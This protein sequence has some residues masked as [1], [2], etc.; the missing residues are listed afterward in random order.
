MAIL[1]SAALAASI[2]LGLASLAQAAELR[3]RA[4]SAGDQVP[5]Q[6]TASKSTAART[7]DRTPVQVSWALEAAEP[8][9]DRP[10]P[11]VRESREYWL[12]ASEA[13]LQRG[14]A[15]PTTAEGALIR[16]SP[17]GSNVNRLTID[18]I[19][20]RSGGRELTGRSA[21]Q[22]VADETSLRAAG[23]DVPDGTVIA[24]LAPST[25][26]GNLQLAAPAA[27]GSYLIHVFEP[28]SST[29][30][31]LTTARDTVVAGQSLRVNAQLTG[32]KAATAKGVLTAPDGHSQSFDLQRQSDGSWQ[33]DVIPD[34]AHA[35]GLE[36]WEVH[37]FASGGD[38]STPV[39]RDAKTAFALS[40]PTARLTG[41]VRTVADT[42]RGG[43]LSFSLGVEAAD[44]SRYQLAGVLYGTASDGTR[45]PMAYAQ[46]AAWIDAGSGRLSL[47]FD[48]ASLGAG[49]LAAPYE[50]RDLRLTNQAD[51]SLVERRERAVEI[52]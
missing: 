5:T 26:K 23:M 36:L 48:A 30:L 27:R 8:L 31:T 7:L 35:S 18:D 16:I 2:A 38:R 32:A 29:V 19:V 42:A 28:T 45:R 46:S 47:S 52:R 50:L 44:A 10:V 43:G 24:K 15:L 4:P 14:V 33:A 37:T 34:A 41:D 1:K 11:F 9:N 49:K 17:H 6:L 21:T 20:I 25:G 39:L 12:D 40:R 22:N 13:E 3:L 51:M